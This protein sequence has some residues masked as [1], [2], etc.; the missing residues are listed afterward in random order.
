MGNRE[1]RGLA[2]VLCRVGACSVALLTGMHMLFASSEVA[3][4]E[5]TAC[6]DYRCDNC[7]VEHDFTEHQVE[8]GEITMNYAEAGD[9]DSPALLLIPEQTGSWWT[10]EA[11]MHLL[12]EDFH[13]F[14]VDLRGQGRTTWTPGRYSIDNFGNDLVRFI[15][16]VIQEPVVVAGNSSGGVIAAWLSAY[17]LPGQV[18]G[19]MYEDPPLF[20]SELNPRYGHSVRQAAGAVFEL[21]KVYL[22]DQWSVSDW[23]GFVEAAQER[24]GDSG[25]FSPSAEPSQSL[26]EYDP[27]WARAFWE[28]T[29]AKTCPHDRM[30]A[31]VKVPVLLTHHF[32]VVNPTTGSLLGALSDFQ[33]DKV[34]ALL[35][36]AGVAVEYHSFPLA[37]HVMHASDPDRYARVLTAWAATL[38]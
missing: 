5:A 26:R 14:A 25:V 4:Q 31:Q 8:L 3:A 1:T 19:A 23:P 32:R 27:E 30:L 33:A 10:Y 29:V 17:A 34:Q 9:P 24:F 16:L 6:A 2:S 13:V 21:Y 12:A 18:R 20:A 28:G 38:P 15:L 22:G 7:F 35:A 37:K 36:E 11:A